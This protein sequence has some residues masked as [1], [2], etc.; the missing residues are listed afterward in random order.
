MKL[1][2]LSFLAFGAAMVVSAVSCSNDNILSEPDKP[3]EADQSFYVP[4]NVNGFSNN[5][6]AGEIGDYDDNNTAYD[7]GAEP[8]FDPGTKDENAVE[9]VYFVFYD[10]NGT[11]LSATDA[12]KVND[13]LQGPKP[14]LN[15]SENSLYSGVVQ[16]DVQRGQNIPAYVLAF[17]NPT[18]TPDFRTSSDF[19]TLA[20]VEKSTRQSLIDADGWF[21][22]SNSVYYGTDEVTNASQ[23]RIMATPIANG[24]LFNNRTDAEAA[25]NSKLEDEKTG[26]AVD[27][28][29]E[30]YAGKVKFSV[31]KDAV[32]PLDIEG[33]VL[34]FVPEAWAVN[35]DEDISFVTKTFFG[36]I[37]D[38]NEFNWD[39]PASYET[40]NS[41][42]N[43]TW[44]SPSFHRSY[45]GQSPSYYTARY[46]RV[47]DDILDTIAKNP[48]LN[49][50]KGTYDLVYYSY[51][52]II[53]NTKVAGPK[54]KARVIGSEDALYPRENT[55]AGKSLW[56]AY[57]DPY[58]SP[59][60]AIASVVLVGHYTV[61]DEEIPAGTRFYVTG[62]STNG[63]HF[64]TEAEM[65][66]FFLDNTI[67]LASD[68]QGTP[69]DFTQAPNSNYIELNHPSWQ[70][71]GGLVMDSRYVTLQLTEAAIG[72]VYA[73]SGDKFVLV[74]KNNIDA[75]NQ[76]VMSAA[77]TAFGFEG[78]KAYFNIPIQHLG[79]YRTDNVNAKK[80]PNGAN[81]YNFGWKDVKSGD[82]GIVRNHVYT[83]NAN[84][85][86][87]LGNAIPRPEDPI[88][89][90]TD[91]N[92]Y[93]I[94]ARIIVLNWA[95]VPTQSVE[96]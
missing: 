92:E 88:V 72:K 32:Q 84:V 66:K 15:N 6:R 9:T 25:L 81:S 12:L 90:P 40:M 86:K 48:S 67:K 27:I 39:A 70:V 57:D 76:N 77:G 71:R 36:Q 83:I 59:R 7:P 47:A 85:I 95:I 89:P 18:N 24:K 74:T 26:S 79:Y 58:A 87:G 45:W 8:N 1:K 49:D 50:P 60:A 69:M 20:A 21:A 56:S 42:L 43:W 38:T 2:K 46:P 80:F 4:I 11:R 54:A 23:F 63:Y 16:V 33:K 78:G 53:G 44:N 30:R 75:V 17:V 19:A 93:Y 65:R 14:G 3:L 82:F 55:V 73:K 31:A 61:N 37:G 10:A 64:Y 96:L 94:G 13:P 51:N 41:L 68:D 52:D 28:Y 29:V 5:S 35:A 62:N 91:P 22:M 34:K